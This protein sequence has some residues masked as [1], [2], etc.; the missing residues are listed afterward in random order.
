MAV[1]ARLRAHPDGSGVELLAAHLPEI[2]RRTLQRR[3]AEL[4]VA[5]MVEAVGAGRGRRYRVAAGV[6]SSAAEL[7]PQDLSPAGIELRGLVRRPIIRR[8]PVGYRRAFLDDYVPNVTAW[9]PA[10]LRGRLHAMGRSPHEG[11]PAG[12]FARQLLDRL[13]IDLSWASSRL[14]GNTYTRLDT[15]NL[16]EFGRYA[17]GRDAREAQMILDHKAAIELL[18]DEAEGIGFNRYT[19]QNLHALLSEGLLPDPGAGGRLRRIPVGISGTVYEP[20]AIPQLIEDC[21]DVLLAKAQAITDPFEQSFFLMVQLPYLQPFEDVNKRVSRLGANIPL[22]KHNLVPLSF[23]DVPERTYVEGLL[24]V[25]ELNRMELLRDVYAWAYERSCRR[26]MVV[27]DTLPTPDPVRQRWRTEI[28]DIV[29]GVVR[30]GGPIDA[31]DVQAE[32]QAEVRAEDVP[33][34]TAMVLNELHGLH[35]GNIARFRLRP[36]EF[37]RW[38]GGLNGDRKVRRS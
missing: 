26:Y 34:V 18:V 32:V 22:I 1:L 35:E 19:L 5:G 33:A 21:F 25:H 27:R 8:D 30:S 2:P 29:A 15:Q 9:V 14:E 24:A 17:E 16:I 38:I 10:G 11:Q 36:S 28:Y 13:L 7:D 31:A 3:L 4:V 37:R 23:V 6:A 12:T 20:T